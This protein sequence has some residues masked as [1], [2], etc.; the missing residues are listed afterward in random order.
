MPKDGFFECFVFLL[1]ITIMHF[2]GQRSIKRIDNPNNRASQELKDMFKKF[3]FWGFMVVPYF[4]FFVI[5]TFFAIS[6]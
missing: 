4:L 6:F 2:F 1:L 3:V 5:Q